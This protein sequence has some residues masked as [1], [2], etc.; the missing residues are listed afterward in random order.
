MEEDEWFYDMPDE[1]DLGDNDYEEDI[2][3]DDVDDCDY[4][5]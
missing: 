1:T 3:I 5:D 4:D 2:V